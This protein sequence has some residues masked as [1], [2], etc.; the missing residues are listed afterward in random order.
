MAVLAG[1]GRR[2][3]N[4]RARESARARGTIFDV[5]TPIQELLHSHHELRAALILAGMHIRKLSSGGREDLALDIIR[6]TLR[7]ARRVARNTGRL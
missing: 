6:R 1:Y 3:P 7:D 5:E 4:L 2:R